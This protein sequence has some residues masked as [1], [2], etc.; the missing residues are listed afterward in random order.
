M[1]FNKDDYEILLDFDFYILLVE[2]NHNCKDRFVRFSFTFNC[3]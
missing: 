1:S 3:I 2:V